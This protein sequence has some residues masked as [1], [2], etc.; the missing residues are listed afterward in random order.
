[1]YEGGGGRAVKFCVNWAVC[2]R[3]GTRQGFHAEFLVV[4]ACRNDYFMIL[5][6]PFD[7]NI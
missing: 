1:M 4:G 6:L 5:K 7:N 3:A 2:A